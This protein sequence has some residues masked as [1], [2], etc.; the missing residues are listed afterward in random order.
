MEGY[1]KWDSSITIVP[2]RFS[3]SFIQS[4]YTIQVGSRDKMYSFI[5]VIKRLTS[6]LIRGYEIIEFF[7]QHARI[8]KRDHT[9][10]VEVFISAS[11]SFS[12]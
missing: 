12:I 5:E 1:R 4:S 8:C 10:N 6:H 2:L 11:S 7:K 3:K 9:V